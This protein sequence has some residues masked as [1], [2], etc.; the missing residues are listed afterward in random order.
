MS[1]LSSSGINR[2]N[3]PYHDLFEQAFFEVKGVVLCGY[4]NPRVNSL[5]DL[6]EDVHWGIPI[7]I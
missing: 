6:L 4:K 3:F 2:G 1:V 5:E 7:Y